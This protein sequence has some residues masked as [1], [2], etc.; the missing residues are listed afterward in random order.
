[1]RLVRALDRRRRVTAVPF[2]RPGFPEAH[3][4]TVAQCEASAWA[5]LPDGRRYPGAAAI[6]LAVAV[7]LGVGLP[8]W[9]YLLP[10]IRQAQERVYR[11]IAAN[12]SRFPGDTPYCEQFPAECGKER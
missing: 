10:G 12:R 1:M 6:N 5:V 11:W 2:Q 8:L 3:G 9:F 7:A 4:L